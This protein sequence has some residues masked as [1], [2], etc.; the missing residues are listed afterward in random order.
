MQNVRQSREFPLFQT[1]S[2]KIPQW[3]ALPDELRQ[4][5]VPLLARLLRQHYTRSVAAKRAEDT[6]DE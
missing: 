3:E 5:T 6:C 1:P 2:P 4:R